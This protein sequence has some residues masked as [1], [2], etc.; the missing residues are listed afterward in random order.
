[1]IVQQTLRI[2]CVIATSLVG[3]AAVA[4]PERNFSG[5]Y[6]CT[7]DAAGGVRFNDDTGSWQGTRF[8]ADRKRIVNIKLMGKEFD[9][10]SQTNRNAYTITWK[11]HGDD[12]FILNCVARGEPKHWIQSSNFISDRGVVVCDTVVGSLRVNLENGRYVEAKTGTYVYGDEN[13]VDA[14]IVVGRCS[15][16]D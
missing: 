7:D 8:I 11:R 15:R 10:I 1:M 6:F 3:C 5:S 2:I 14:A 9:P 16:I 4:E 13:V 12:G